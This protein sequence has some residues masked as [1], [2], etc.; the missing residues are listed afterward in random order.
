MKKGISLLLFLVVAGLLTAETVQAQGTAGSC[1]YR[2]YGRVPVA[3]PVWLTNWNTLHPTTV[4]NG[5]ITF[6]VFGTN[7]ITND[8]I[9]SYYECQ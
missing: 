1:A 3:Y 9:G 4:T 6:T 5:G 7:S 2:I 8:V